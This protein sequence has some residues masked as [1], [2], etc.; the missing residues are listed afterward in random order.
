MIKPNP[1]V[2]GAL[3]RIGYSEKVLVDWMDESLAELKEKVMFQTDEVQLRIL[4][5]RAQELSEIR[6]LIKKAPE[7][8][9]KA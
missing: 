4:Q 8:A 3:A 6:E 7:L 1:Q 5:G 9:R 2:I